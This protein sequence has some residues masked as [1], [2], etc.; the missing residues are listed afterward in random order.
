MYII[1]YLVSN[2]FN[3]NPFVFTSKAKTLDLA[4][5]ELKIQ[6]KKDHYGENVFFDYNEIID[7]IDYILINKNFHIIIL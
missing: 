4:I 7:E 6:L 5:E 3:I 2:E 1:P